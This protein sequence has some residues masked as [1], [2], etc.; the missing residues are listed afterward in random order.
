MPKTFNYNNVGTKSLSLGDLYVFLKNNGVDGIKYGDNFTCSGYAFLLK[1]RADAVGIKC[2]IVRIWFYSHDI[3]ADKAV[4]AKTS[5][6][7][8]VF[9]V[10]KYGLT[11]VEP[12]DNTMFYIKNG[13]SY[14]ALL[15]LFSFTKS[16]DLSNSKDIILPDINLGDGKDLIWQ[17]D[18]FWGKPF[19]SQLDYEGEK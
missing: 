10:D 3:N 11:F 4:M 7:I 8:N 16:V 17:T 1:S 15:K 6:M 18:I 13:T 14:R 19:S 2:G 9:N 5:H 12:Q